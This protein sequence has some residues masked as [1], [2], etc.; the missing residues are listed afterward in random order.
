MST[1]LSPT[2]RRWNRILGS[3]QFWLIAAILIISGFLHYTS[4]IRT[5]P[6]TLFGISS[7]L[8]RHAVERVLL[9]I[10]ITYA[11]FTFG[12]AGGLLT[13][14][15]AILIMLPR[16]L[17]VSAYPLDAFFEMIAVILVGGLVSWL[18]EIQKREKELRQRV[19]SEL[20][21]VNAI[22]AI[23]SQSLELE[24]ILENALAKVMEVMDL[25]AR[26]GVFL[27]NA[28]T[29][30]LHLRTHQ[31]LS[32][33]SVRQEAIV[34]V[35]ECLCGLVAQS[36]EVLFLEEGC[37]DAR[38]TRRTE[39]GPH[40]HLIVPLKSRD[41]VLGVM[42]FYPQSAFRADAR[43]LT[44]FASLGNQIGI[45]IENARLYER[46]R[47]ALEESR[48]SEER[49]R[50]YVRHITRAQEDERKRIARELHDDTAQTL[51][52]LSRRLD[53]LA[54]YPGGLPEPT[55]QRMEE[56]RE[57]SS[58]ILKGVRRFSQDLRPPALDDLG[59]LPAL[60]GLTMD[61]AKR[62]GIEAKL[63]VAG[64]PRRLPAETELVL[65]RI[66][67][68]ALRNVE[69]HSEATRVTILVEFSETIQITVSDDGRG[70]QQPEAIGSLAQ[71]GRLGLIGMQER[72][73]LL[74]GTFTVH[75][76]PGQG[77]TIVV[78]VPA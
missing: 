77:T 4:Q 51:A 40:A 72:A 66:T 14:F 20:E 2:K 62:D 11:A 70:F 56:L 38:H 28:K 30:E 49:L 9:V 10:P 37:Q 69:K 45:G 32:E 53:T 43:S 74:G 59:L 27:L 34:Q 65:F 15:V 61:L 44:L 29:Q 63:E 12:L 55:L 7:H 57:L 1:T 58:N 41:K 78:D 68:E 46:E 54:T 16:V 26:A 42:F 39:M 22:S 6:V 67:Q 48:V 3:H 36:G 73:Q 18:A 35:G 13:L 31:G 60:E 24:Q 8:T 76:E 23:V 64:R 25:E 71:V 47:Q 19:I 75:S 52:L 33:E 50:F 17:F 21:A 5:S